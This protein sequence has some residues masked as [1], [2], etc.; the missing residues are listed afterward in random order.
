MRS[1]G[2]F[3]RN[4]VV[5]IEDFIHHLEAKRPEGFRAEE[6]KQMHETDIHFLYDGL[7]A[8]EQNIRDN[9]SRLPGT[10][11]E[12]FRM[13][14]FPQAD[15]RAIYTEAMQR[16]GI[17]LQYKGSG[18]SPG[19][20]DLPITATTGKGQDLWHIIVQ[21]D[22]FHK[23]W[24]LHSRTCSEH[25]TGILVKNIVEPD[26][27]DLHAADL[28]PK[29]GAEHARHQSESVIPRGTYQQMIS[30]GKMENYFLTQYVLNLDKTNQLYW[31]ADWAADYD[32]RLQNN[33]LPTDTEDAQTTFTLVEDVYKRYELGRAGKKPFS[34]EKLIEQQTEAY[35]AML[36]KYPD[37]QL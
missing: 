28:D 33:E 32:K 19:R 4:D 3:R 12:L 6:L 37:L 29:R 8:L 34:I 11:R 20:D 2:E 31:A 30:S 35:Q 17:P 26:D 10:K 9:R 25:I 14:F 5:T 27:L 7:S 22:T 18:G 15:P 13:G 36:E 23:I 1:S 16:C 21:E 24:E